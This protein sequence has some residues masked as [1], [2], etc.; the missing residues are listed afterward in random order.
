MNATIEAI[1]TILGALAA[2]G[3]LLVTVRSWGQHQADRDK[4]ALQAA[5]ND[6]YAKGVQSQAAG[7]A[8]AASQLGDAIR[9]GAEARQDARDWE[10]RYNDLRDFRRRP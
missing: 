7:L 6:G 9:D 8:L 2:V 3:A 4:E 10:K 1:A 5:Y